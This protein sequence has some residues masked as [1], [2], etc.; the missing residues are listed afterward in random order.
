MEKG[1]GGGWQSEGLLGR[2]MD[3]A[4][5]LLLDALRA[6]KDDGIGEVLDASN[7]CVRAT[8]GKSIFRENYEPEQL[9]QSLQCRP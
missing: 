6:A 1:R 2:K 9:P 3:R 8:S 5:T 4:I 7:G